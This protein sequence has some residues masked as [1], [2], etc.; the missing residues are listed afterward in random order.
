MWITMFT[1]WKKAGGGGMK[2][3]PKEEVA[4]RIALMDLK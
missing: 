3:G 4:L 2:E 1:S